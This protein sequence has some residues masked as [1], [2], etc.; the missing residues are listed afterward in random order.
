MNPATAAQTAAYCFPAP[1]NADRR[2]FN[3][4]RDQS[5]KERVTA[6]RGNLLAAQQLADPWDFLGSIHHFLHLG[7]ALLHKDWSGPIEAYARQQIKPSSQAFYTF[8]N[9]LRSGSRQ[10]N[11]DTGTYFTDFADY[12]RYILEIFRGADEDPLAQ[13]EEVLLLVCVSSQVHPHTA[14]TYVA[15]ANLIREIFGYS[16][17]AY[18]VE[19]QIA[20][21]RIRLPIAANKTL[22]DYELHGGPIRTYAVLMK[23]LHKINASF[24]RTSF[25]SYSASAPPKKRKT[26][27]R[28]Q[29]MASR[30][31]KL[32][33]Y[34]AK[35]P[36]KGGK[37][38]VD[39]RPACSHCNKP[40]HHV[41]SCWILHPDKLAGFK[42]RRDA[43]RNP[44]ALP[45]AQL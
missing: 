43:R 24:K 38:R 39:N 31:D 36:Y 37:I 5:C 2:A 22:K 15:L 7:S 8:D 28:I 44:A 1:G 12:K 35:T 33:R 41:D 34:D 42:A 40:G 29:S 11:V 19:Q 32:P 45:P 3:V 6:P 25:A 18:T 21:I 14:Q 20:R 4:H 9:A 30:G 10:R 17:S 27:A 16:P 26:D 23:Y 13:I